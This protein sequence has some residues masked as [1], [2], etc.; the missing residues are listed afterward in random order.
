MKSGGASSALRM[1]AL[2]VFSARAPAWSPIAFRLLQEQRPAHEARDGWRSKARGERRTSSCGRAGGLCRGDASIRLPSDN[3][4]VVC[5]CVCGVH[6]FTVT[7]W[8]TGVLTMPLVTYWVGDVRL[9]PAP[10]SPSSYE[11]QLGAV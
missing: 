6:S 5:K 3:L 4:S 1:E 9:L 11:A 2:A 7:H 8:D 10:D